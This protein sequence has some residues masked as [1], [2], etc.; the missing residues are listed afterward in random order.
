MKI[1]T[2]ITLTILC[3]LST[4]AQEKSTDYI[5]SAE[6]FKIITVICPMY[7]PERGGYST[8]IGLY[9]ADG[10]ILVQA[11]Y[12]TYGSR[13]TYFYVKEGTEVI[14][15]RAF[16]AFDGA[17]VYIPSSVKSIAPD[18]FTSLTAKSSL[19]M[20]LYDDAKEEQS[21]VSAPAK[22]NTYATEI[23]RYTVDGKRINEPQPGI[24]I[25]QLS[26]NTAKKVLER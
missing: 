25:V 5:Y 16:Q 14:A 6:G 23:A 21:N 11:I 12:D 20:G 26:D 15:S 13:S 19:V 7:S 8:C 1:L 9:S 10:K 18:A 24:N 2:T 3:A 4:F 17:L 22:D